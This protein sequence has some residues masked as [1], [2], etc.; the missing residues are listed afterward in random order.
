MST[1]ALPCRL[2]VG[3]FSFCR[4]LLD[5]SAKRQNMSWRWTDLR[6]LGISNMVGGYQP[7]HVLFRKSVYGL[8]YIDNSVI[9]V[10]S[11][12]PIFVHRWRAATKASRRFVS[13]IMAGDRTAGSTSCAPFVYHLL[14]SWLYLSMMLKDNRRL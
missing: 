4:R 6:T 5:P 10:I 12:R 14:F 3:N 13:D 7:V 2:Q 11:P 8:E 1:T 9:L